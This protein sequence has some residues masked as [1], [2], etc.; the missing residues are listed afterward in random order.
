[1]GLFKNYVSQTRRPEGFLGKMMLKGMNSGHAKMA[2]WGMGAVK[3]LSPKMIAELGCGGGRNAAALL[4]RYPEAHVDA[5]DYSPL[6]VEK[7]AEY[8]RAAV[9]SGRCT[10]S[11]GDVQ[12]LK[13]CESTYDL[14]TA[15]ETVYFWPGLEKCFSQVAKILKPGGTFMI[16]NESDGTDKGSLRFERIIDGM[17]CYTAQ[18]I[19]GALKKAGFSSVRSVHHKTKPWLIVIAVK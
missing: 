2:D 11:Q 3:E 7:A 1:M 16:V 10:V 12:E 4:E 15:F 5:V 14:A 9:E 6:S 19:G 8:N 17:K 13:L 18:D